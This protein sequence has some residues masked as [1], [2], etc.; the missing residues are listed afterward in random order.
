MSTN[1][2][3]N[4]EEVDLGTLFAIIGRGFSN[5]FNFLGNIF[6]GLFNVVI[7]L[8]LFIKKHL[9]KFT[10]AALIGG[11]IGGFIEFKKEISFGSDMLLQPNFKSARQLYNNINFYDD[12]VKQKDSTLLAKTFG[13]TKEQAGSLRKF[14]ITPVITDSDILKRYDELILSVDTL[15]AKSY[16]FD[17]FRRMFT[18]YDYKVHQVHVESIDKTVFSNLNR[19]IIESI[20]NNEYFNKLK[21]LTNENLNRTD[22]L[23][24]KNLK[25]IDTLRKV[26]M[27]VLLE[28]AKKENSGTSINFAADKKEAKELEIFK[29]NRS[30]NKDLKD[31]SEDISEKSEVINVISNFQPVGYE[32][33]GL[34]NNYIF[35]LSGSA[36]LI[37]L[38]IILLDDLNKYLK[39][40][41]E[42]KK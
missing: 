3:Q 29:T 23:L 32:L 25:Q 8:L 7:Q 13:L 14:E 10:T 24:R 11:F 42:E 41:K 12:L 4:D 19:V 6:K 33:K 39:K 18:K 5:F 15:T 34:N 9:V 2:Q 26:Y 21:T 16:S 17:E 28:E 1:N 36:V 27:S 30:I 35:I 20:T 22:S 37:I 40:Y 38:I 31:I